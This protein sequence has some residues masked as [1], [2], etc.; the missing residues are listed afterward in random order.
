MKRHEK[1]EKMR[2]PRRRPLRR[3]AALA[4]SLA[5]SI[6]GGAGAVWQTVL[7]G[8]RPAFV[9]D[10]KDGRATSRSGKAPAKF[11]QSCEEIAATASLATGTIRGVRDRRGISLVFSRDIPDRTH[12]QFR[13]AWHLER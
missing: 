2:G 5:R 9:I 12:Q 11:L 7:F 10:L 1:I 3:I 6:A 8:S 4:R 13:N